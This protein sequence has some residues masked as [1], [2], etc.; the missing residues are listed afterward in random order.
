MP[1]GLGGVPGWPADGETAADADRTRAGRGPHDKS[2]SNGREPDA[3]VAVSPRGEGAQGR[4][5]PFIDNTWGHRTGVARAWRG[6]GA[7]CR[8]FFG[9]GDARRGGCA[10][11]AEWVAATAAARPG[12]PTFCGDAL[13]RLA[14]PQGL[15]LG[16]RITSELGHT[17]RV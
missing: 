6:R 11:L 10:P 14:N 5:L 1:A 9:L 8:S 4:A 2:Q 7:G 16:R 13:Q 17:H 12:D 3:G 15:S